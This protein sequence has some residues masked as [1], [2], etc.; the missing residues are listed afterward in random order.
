MVVCGFLG[1][2]LPTPE[3]RRPI[4]LEALPSIEKKR[5]SDRLFVPNAL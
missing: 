4:K 5:K 2:G 3:V 1:R